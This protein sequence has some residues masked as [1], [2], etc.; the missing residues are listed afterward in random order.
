MAKPKEILFWEKLCPVG[1]LRVSGTVLR[2]VWVSFQSHA[3]GHPCS[4][5]WE[6]LPLSSLNP[7]GCQAGLPFALVEKGSLSL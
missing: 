1:A 3:R 7:T 5:W 6:V 2:T 4:L